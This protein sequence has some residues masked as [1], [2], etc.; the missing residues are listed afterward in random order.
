MLVSFPLIV[1]VMFVYL[2]HIVQNIMYYKLYNHNTAHT[3]NSTLNESKII[4]VV[5]HNKT[6]NIGEFNNIFIE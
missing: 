4:H 1:V 3:V 5:V 6:H 2:N